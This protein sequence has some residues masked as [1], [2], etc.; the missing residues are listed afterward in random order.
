MIADRLLKSCVLVDFALKKGY[1]KLDKMDTY[2][3]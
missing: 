3:W 2:G 1:N